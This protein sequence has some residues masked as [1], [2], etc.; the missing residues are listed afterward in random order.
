RV[1]KNSD[2]T[3]GRGTVM[4]DIDHHSYIADSVK[5]R[6]IGPSGQSCYGLKDRTA[7]LM[8]KVAASPPRSGGTRGG[9]TTQKG[10]VTDVVTAPFW[11]I[12]RKLSPAPAS[13]YYCGYP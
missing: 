6:S 11:G 12:R 2:P 3:W 8:S 7:L 10:A 13:R 4:T 1:R 9:D 5:V